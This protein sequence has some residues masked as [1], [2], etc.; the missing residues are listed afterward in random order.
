MFLYVVVVPMVVGLSC[1]IVFLIAKN[2]VSIQWILAL[3]SVILGAALSQILIYSDTDRN[4]LYFRVP[5]LV[6]TGLVLMVASL[7]LQHEATLRLATQLRLFTFTAV[8]YSALLLVLPKVESEVLS[9][10]FLAGVG[11]VMSQLMTSFRISR[12]L[13]RHV[14][15]SA[16]A[17]ALLL[18]PPIY[19]R[20]RADL[21]RFQKVAIEGIDRQWESY[22]GESDLANVSQ[23]LRNAS[24]AEDLL[25]MSICELQLLDRD[26]CEV[27]YR[28][29]ALTGR[30]FLA[31]DPRFRKSGVT[32]EM[33]NDVIISSTMGARSQN[34]LLQFLRSRDVTVLVIDK[35]RV[36]ED[37]ITQMKNSGQGVQ[38]ENSSFAVIKI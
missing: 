34:S 8:T 36:S 24:S 23:F 6:A 31:L 17:L 14:Y 22:V 28:I 15:P 32:E 38:F 12:G 29:A 4:H 18:I 16:F 33:W 5:G 35:S 1:L 30:R 3:G 21:N 7:S 25:A 26:I 20:A 9:P 10:L 37:W 2:S 19:E 27:D 11:A 13:R